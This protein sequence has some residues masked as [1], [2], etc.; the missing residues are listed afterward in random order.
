MSD[1]FD[2]YF[3]ENFEK[4]FEKYRKSFRK[5]SISIPGTFQE[6]FQKKNW[7]I[8]RNDSEIFDIHFENYFGKFWESN[9]FEKS[10][11]LFQKISRNISGSYY[12]HNFQNYFWKI[13]KKISRI[14]GD[15]KKFLNRNP[16]KKS[17][18]KKIDAAG[19]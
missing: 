18:I 11:K 19:N 1:I 6:I 10:R 14:I 8:S 17:K 7:R 16:G 3:L 13:P 12:Y 5:F 9:N 15:E 2:K 4:Y